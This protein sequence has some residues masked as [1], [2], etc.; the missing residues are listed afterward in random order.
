MKYKSNENRESY[1]HNILYRQK[2]Y[3]ISETVATYKTAVSEYLK[4][5][6][7]SDLNFSNKQF[8]GKYLPLI[9]KIKIHNFREIKYLIKPVKML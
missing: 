5:A 7:N 9:P 1:I 6:E 2:N 4:K 8:S 3:K